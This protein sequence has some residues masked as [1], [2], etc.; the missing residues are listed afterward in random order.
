MNWNILGIVGEESTRRLPQIR[1]DDLPIDE[2]YAHYMKDLREVAQCLDCT[3]EELVR[4]V[5][6]DWI[7]KE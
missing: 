3:V 1:V 4:A 5:V 6:I 7:D 2:S